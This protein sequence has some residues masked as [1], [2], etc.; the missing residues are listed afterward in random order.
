MVGRPGSDSERALNSMLAFVNTTIPCGSRP[1]T[2]YMTVGIT[3][4]TQ[5]DLIELLTP[6]FRQ[7]LRLEEEELYVR[8]E[9]ASKDFALV[10]SR[11]S[12]WWVKA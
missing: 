3:S 7:K 11:S 4:R 10:S 12:S 8:Q 2:R 6:A 1:F 5:I 9:L